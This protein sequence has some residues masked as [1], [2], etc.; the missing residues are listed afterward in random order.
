[1]TARPGFVLEVD[2]S[3]PPTLFWNGEGFTLE[4]LPE[5]SR[6]I[7]APEPLNALKDP[8]AAIRHAL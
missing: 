2:G 6:V 8:V 3:T 1:M 5:G 4:R 7:Y